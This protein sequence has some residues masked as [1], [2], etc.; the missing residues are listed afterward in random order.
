MT[1]MRAHSGFS[2]TDAWPL[3]LLAAAF[4]STPAALHG[5]VS[6][7][8]PPPD[9]KWGTG[10]W[11]LNVFAGLLNDAP[12]W[13]P[14]G[15]GDQYRRDAIIG[16]RVGYVFPFNL[17]VEGAFANSLFR[18][19]LAPNQTTNVNSFWFEGQ[20][21]Y[22]LQPIRN[23]QL[24]ISGGAGPVLFDTNVETETNLALDYGLGARYFVSRRV[25]I[26]GDARMHQVIDALEKTRQVFNPAADPSDL[27]VLELSGGLSFYL[28]GPKD[29]DGDGVYDRYDRCPDTPRGVVV[30]EFGCPVDSDLDGVPDGVDRCP[31]TP[32]GAI[33]D[34][35]GCPQDSDGD[36]VWDG[37]DQCPDTPRGAVVDE[38]G[39]PMD[40]DGDGVY[41]GIDRCPGTPEGAVVDEFGCSEVQ[42]GLD[43]GRLVLFNVYFNFDQEIARPES[44]LV[45]DEVGATLLARPELVIE[46]QGHTDAIGSDAYNMQLSQRR[47]DS[48]LRYLLTNFPE[49]DP[50]RFTAKGYGKSQ[51]LA[52]NTFPEGRQEN[53]RVE[54]VVT[55]GLD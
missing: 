4:L 46:I 22:N 12:N 55:A 37:I 31:G 42:L 3:L 5:Q 24:F 17:F 20:L 8:P 30:D 13:E 49:L 1:S 51:P 32:R 28:G 52:A 2:T 25:A 40:S 36:G 50:S 47:A 38:V 6:A 21:G 19:K 35:F 7:T 26:R 33:V 39:C 23:L 44:K 27:F 9:V 48:V 43:A 14:D 16:G 10:A 11:E 34:Q 15:I 53:R 29:S 18:A 41:D 45:L 54:F